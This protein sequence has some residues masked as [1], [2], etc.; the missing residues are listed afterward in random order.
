MRKERASKSSRPRG[1]LLPDRAHASL[2]SASDRLRLLSTLMAARVVFG[3]EMLDLPPD[4]LMRYFQ[5]LADDLDH[6]LR[7]AQ[8][9]R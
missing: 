5:R 3:S 7:E 2:M 1:Y 6:V 4:T 8:Y 9:Q